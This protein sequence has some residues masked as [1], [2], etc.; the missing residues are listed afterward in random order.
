[1]GNKRQNAAQGAETRE[2]M[3]A[4]IVDYIQMHGY[5]PTVRE[6]GEAVGLYSTA[7]VHGH[8]KKMVDEGM[9]ET[10]AGMSSPRA[11]R[12]PGYAFVKTAGGDE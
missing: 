12:V 10:D 1:M 9:I 3:L 8:L 4:A 11:I 2:K 7:S 6:I 5:S